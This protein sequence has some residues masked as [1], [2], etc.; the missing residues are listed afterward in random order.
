MN[1][2]QQLRKLSSDLS[3]VSDTNSGYVIISGNNDPMYDFEATCKSDQD[4][5]GAIQG[6]WHGKPTTVAIISE[7]CIEYWDLHSPML[8]TKSDKFPRIDLKAD[9]S[10]EDYIMQAFQ[11][12]WHLNVKGTDY[13]IRQT[14]QQVRQYWGYLM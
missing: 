12:L 7:T 10:T 9:E 5:Y 3:Y 4:Y 1:L 14:N 11:R 13:L 6:Q 8:A 2:I